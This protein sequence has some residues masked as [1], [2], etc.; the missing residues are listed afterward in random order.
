MKLFI[1][2]ACATETL[3]KWFTTLGSGHF[4]G[5]FLWPTPTAI[6]IQSSHS[7]QC[8]VSH[9]PAKLPSHYGPSCSFR[10]CDSREE[11]GE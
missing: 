2:T 11:M 6:C 4:L 1:F 8:A 9:K 7:N 5:V 10:H 3:T